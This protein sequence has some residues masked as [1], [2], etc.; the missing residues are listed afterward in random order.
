[1]SQIF[2]PS[3]E[4]EVFVSMSYDYDWSTG[5]LEKTWKPQFWHAKCADSP[6]S[7]SLY[8]FPVSINLRG[9]DPVPGQ[10]AALNQA[11]LDA[12]AE[13]QKTVADLNEQL[14]KLLAIT[15]DPSTQEPVD[16]P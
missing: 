10:V 14:S 12:L 2:P 4:A 9:F 11:K 3:V 16:V 15:N 13:Y 8:S 7:I 1:M 6:T 5:G